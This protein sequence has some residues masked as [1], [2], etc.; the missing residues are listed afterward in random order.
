MAEAASTSD[1]QTMVVLPALAL[2]N[3]KWAIMSQATAL[4]GNSEK[5]APASFPD[6]HPSLDPIHTT[7]QMLATRAFTAE[8]A[9]QPLVPAPVHAADEE[10]ALHEAEPPNVR[11]RNLT[12][13]EE[14]SAAA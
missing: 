1:D 3:L 13:D 4:F 7:V 12:L 6:P 10:A 2:E 8:N 14:M 5:S 9:P 11:I